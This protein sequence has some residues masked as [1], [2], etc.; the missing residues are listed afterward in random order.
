[1]GI[2]KYGRIQ[3]QKGPPGITDKTLIIDK[4]GS[5]KTDNEYEQIPPG[6]YTQKFRNLPYFLKIAKIRENIY[7]S[8][9][10][11]ALETYRGWRKYLYNACYKEILLGTANRLLILA[12]L[13]TIDQYFWDSVFEPPA[14][15][16]FQSET[17][18]GNV[19]STQ[20]HF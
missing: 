5:L 10:V 11:C 16:K 19:S 13:E 12:E 6:Q 20:G 14:N 1:M 15:R 3:H 9:G 2:L 8:D 7:V 17:Q 4:D 18:R